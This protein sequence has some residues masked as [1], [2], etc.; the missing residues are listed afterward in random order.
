V[1]VGRGKQGV[2]DPT[3]V[4]RD[5][6]HADA[7][8]RLAASQIV[9]KEAFRVSSN[10]V[11]A[12]LGN[13]RATTPLIAA[14]DDPDAKVAGYAVMALAEI[15]RRY[16][17]DDR[18]YPGVVRLLQ[19][20]SAR[21]RSWA[22]AAAV[23]LRGQ[24]SIDDVLPLCRDRVKNVRHTVLV[25]LCHLAMKRSSVGPA[26][27]RKLQE[28]AIGALADTDFE[29]RMVASNILRDIGNAAAL[30]D[31]QRAVRKEKH[32]FAKD[33]MMTAIAFIERRL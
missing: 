21:S 25:S 13:R 26:S 3:K 31:L 30:E 1:I 10:R 14:L 17:K 28:V 20:K 27:R 18:A 23:C 16:F 24:K 29:V 7:S 32:D 4:L 9:Q 8:V 6:R 2:F 15:T 5:L 12:W 19:S 22:A 33:S 11:L